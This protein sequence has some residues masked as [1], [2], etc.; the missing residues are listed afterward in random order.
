MGGG[1]SP[2]PELLAEWATN[3]EKYPYGE[4]RGPFMLL[5]LSILLG[6]TLAV[7][8]ARLWARC[9]VRRNAGL[10]DWLIVAALPFL[11]AYN[12]CHLLGFYLYGVDRHAWE[13]TF[14]QA[15]NIRIVT[16]AIAMCYMMVTSLVKI[17]ILCFYRRL[18]EGVMTQSWLWTVRGSIGF[19]IAYGFIFILMLFVACRPMS[20]FWNKMDPEWATS[21]DFKC[22]N[23]GADFIAS[24]VVSVIQD[25]AVCILPLL[26]VRRLQMP[27]KQKW[28]L[29][30][31]FGI[32]FFL[33]LCG[34]MRVGY[35]YKVYY[36]SYDTT[37]EALPV[38]CWTL[39]ETHF[40]IICASAP[41]LKLFFRRVL[42]P[43]S[44]DG[45][46]SG[47]RAQR[48]GYDNV[49][50][51]GRGT[52]ATK[53][54]AGIYMEDMQAYIEA[55]VRAEEAAKDSPIFTAFP[56]SRGESKSPA[57]ITVTHEVDVSFSTEGDALSSGGQD[58]GQSK[59]SI[60]AKASNE[61]LLENPFSRK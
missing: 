25:A 7:V 42:Q 38:W 52:Q 39:V 37:W 19:V 21:H 14:F 34:T 46:Y 54:G 15:V 18:S 23:E 8:A 32:G 10:D 16:W 55:K 40:A 43:T 2:P 53:D 31:I 12:V 29:G 33:C 49:G 61:S 3:R 4:R 28:A 57:C 9:K 22:F 48:L 59:K 24:A 60:G 26:V 30:A 51:G 17:S 13:L 11:I 5:L 36:Q 1:L 47:A 41:A 44:P 20:A 56:A 6:L 58:D 27:R 50:S 35:M 45:S